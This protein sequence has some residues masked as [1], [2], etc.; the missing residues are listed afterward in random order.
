[1]RRLALVL[2][3]GGCF[4][5][6]GLSKEFNTAGDGGGTDGGG[7]PDGQGCVT[8]Q[9]QVQVPGGTFRMGCVTGDTTCNA[10]EGPAHMVTVSGFTIDRVEVTQR[11]FNMCVAASMC[12]AP[13]CGLW[14]PLQTPDRPVECVTWASAKNFCVF[15]GGRLPTEAEWEMAARGPNGASNEFPWGNTPPDCTWV[16]YAA[17]PQ[18]QGIWTPTS[19]MNASPFGAL[20]MS[21]NIREWVNDWYSANYY[22]TSIATNPMGPGTGTARVVRGGSLNS[23]V[24]EIRSSARDSYDPTMFDIDLGFRCVNRT[25]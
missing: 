7:N 24:S 19:C 4:D 22:A 21:G 25:H 12:A 11:E 3:L 5:F 20:D 17:C 23:I 8:M 13:P 6:D 16:N 2:A 14:D 9:G 1:M 10:D 15:V 18:S